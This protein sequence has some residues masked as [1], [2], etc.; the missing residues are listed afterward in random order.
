MF[1]T[2]RKRFGIYAGQFY[3]IPIPKHMFREQP[4]SGRQFLLQDQLSFSDLN[5]REESIANVVLF[6]EKCVRISNG[7]EVG[8]L[9]FGWF[10]GFVSEES[11][12]F[13]I[14]KGDN[15][16][17]YCGHNLRG[18]CASMISSGGLIKPLHG[19]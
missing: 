5:R 15:S 14:D 18:V 13:N 4:P 8:R 19:T 2:E 9:F 3:S 12:I 11:H 1:S 17:H 16:F 6:L 7:T 10:C